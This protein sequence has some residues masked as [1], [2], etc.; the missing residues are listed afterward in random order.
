MLIESLFPTPIGFFNFDNFLTQDQIN[1]IDSQDS[2]NNESNTFSANRNIL[3]ESALHNLSILIQKC[4][5]EYFIKTYCPKDNVN[6]KLTQSWINWTKKGQYHHRHAHQNSLISGCYYVKADKNVDRIYFYKDKYNLLN[7][8]PIEWNIYNSN[9]WWF[10]VGAG[11]LIFFPSH[12]VHDV[13]K[14]EYDDTRI[15]IA[16][17]FFPVGEIGNSDNLDYLQ[18]S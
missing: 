9:S 3:N 16:F 15:S 12:L 1:F 11:D 7:L 4:A 5:N 13:K 6:I 17:N 14:V 2:V 10:S 18:L 8:N